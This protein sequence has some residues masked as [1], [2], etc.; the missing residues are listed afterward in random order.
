MISQSYLS[1]GIYRQ[2]QRSP[3]LRL[4]RNRK[5]EV[6]RFVVV[7]PSM[8][9]IMNPYQA[10]INIA[11]PREIVQEIDEGRAYAM[12][13]KGTYRQLIAHGT[14]WIRLGPQR[15]PPSYAQSQKENSPAGHAG[16]MLVAK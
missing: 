11:I 5:G 13:R 8:L 15:R 14:Q 4:V 3:W 10:H 1:A 2:W 7:A 6:V 12:E 9:R 16:R